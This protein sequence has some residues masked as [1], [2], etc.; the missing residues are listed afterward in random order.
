[1]SQIGNIIPHNKDG[2]IVNSLNTPINIVSI[3][4]KLN[5]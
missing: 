1:M 2:I 4:F 3:L 5:K